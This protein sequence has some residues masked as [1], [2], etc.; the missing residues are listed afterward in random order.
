MPIFSIYI[1]LTYYRI[2]FRTWS[3]FTPRCA[4]CVM[5][6]LKQMNYYKNIW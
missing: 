6:N 2:L 4:R 1:H 3:R 5:K